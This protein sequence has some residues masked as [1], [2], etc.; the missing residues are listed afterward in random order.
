MGRRRTWTMAELQRAKKR[1]ENG[2]LWD[3]IAKDFGIAADTVRKQVRTHLGPL[4]RK[5]R[6]GMTREYATKIQ[7]A[8]V[9]RN[10]ENASWTIIAEHIEWHASKQALR[11]AVVR[12]ADENELTVR[13]GFPDIRHC[14]WENA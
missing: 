3:D 14:R 4:N 12:F 1:A 6:K 13:Q 9:M 10:V 7:R 11:K 5:R 2:E 8:L